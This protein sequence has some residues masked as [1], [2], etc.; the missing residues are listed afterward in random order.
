[1][2]LIPMSVVFIFHFRMGQTEEEMMKEGI[3]KNRK[4]RSIIL[5]ITVE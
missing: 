4:M 5:R 3:E 1:M 2:E